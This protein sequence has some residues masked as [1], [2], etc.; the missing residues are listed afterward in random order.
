MS[1]PLLKES[2]RPGIIFS[3]TADLTNI[4]GK[5]LRLNHGTI[6]SAAKVLVQTFGRF[7]W[8][9]KFIGEDFRKVAPSRNTAG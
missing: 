5:V 1:F 4:N 8:F 3:P 2:L 9:T 7:G 6:C